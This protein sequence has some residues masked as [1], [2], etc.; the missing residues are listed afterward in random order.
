M[1]KIIVLMVL[2]ALTSC[3][4]ANPVIE[5]TSSRSSAS[6]ASSQSDSVEYI[7]TAFGYVINIPSAVYIPGNNSATDSRVAFGNVPLLTKAK[8]HEYDVYLFGS[9]E[10]DNCK[11]LGVSKPTVIEDKAKDIKTQWGRVDF[12]DKSQDVPIGPQPVCEPLTI[13][14]MGPGTTAERWEEWERSPQRGQGYYA[15]CSE[16]DGKQVLICISQVTDNPTLA[17]QIFD[18][19]RWTK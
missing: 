10:A 18:S 7:N 17:K 19:F 4:N 2:L 16:H 14:S 3:R 15:L 11:N 5:P 9:L 12:W 1:K 13:Y 6:L 8:G